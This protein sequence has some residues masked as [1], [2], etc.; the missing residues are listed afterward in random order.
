MFSCYADADSFTVS[1]SVLFV[2]SSVAV[3][4]VVGVKKFVTA[5][6]ACCPA[7]STCPTKA[8]LAS[9]SALA[10]SISACPIPVNSQRLIKHLWSIY[11]YSRPKKH[12]PPAHDIF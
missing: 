3:S 6:H 7:S 8:W 2:E 4:S 10:V 1:E 5:D 12:A 11:Q 9:I